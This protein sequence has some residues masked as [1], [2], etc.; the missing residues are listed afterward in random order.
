VVTVDRDRVRAEG[1]LT[2][3]LEA[4]AHAIELLG[5]TPLDQL[6]I[7]VVLASG[8]VQAQISD[9][10]GKI[11]IGRAP[12]DVLA[13]VFRFAGAPAAQ[14][15]NIARSIAE[16]RKPFASDSANAA[17]GSSAQPVKPD[18]GGQ[19]FTDVRQLLQLP[20]V[21]PE[22]LAAIA[23]LTTVFGSETVNP[24]TA[25][26]EVLA[27]LPGMDASRVRAFLQARHSLPAAPSS[28]RRWEQRNDI[29]R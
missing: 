17:A 19:P 1:L 13:A 12:V 8:S 4:A 20:A 16:W 11:D 27:A 9:E 26:A 2:A 3:G 23:P 14:A 24:L 22:W 18:Y 6:D 21:A 10:G 15:D 5:D 7:R 29:W 25:R 28:P